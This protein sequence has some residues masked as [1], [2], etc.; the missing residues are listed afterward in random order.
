LKAKIE[1][2]KNTWCLAELSEKIC[3]LASENGRIT[4]AFISSELQANRNTIK[5]HLQNLVKVGRLLKHGKGRGV[6][7]SPF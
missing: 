4:V 2:E 1:R 7:Y 6:Y 5:K 3:T